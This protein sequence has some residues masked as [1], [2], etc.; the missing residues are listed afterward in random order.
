MKVG[1][2]GWLVPAWERT[3]RGP[4]YLEVTL[5]ARFRNRHHGGPSASQ[6]FFL[7]NRAFLFAI[8]RFSALA[9]FKIV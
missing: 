5:A 8:S 2:K 7:E 9:L 3:R 4:A 1:K 6:L